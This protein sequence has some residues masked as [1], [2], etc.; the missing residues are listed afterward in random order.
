MTKYTLQQFLKDLDEPYAWPGGYPRYFITNDGEAL[1]FVAARENQ[2]LIEQSISE[3][4]N[5]GWQVVACEINWEDSSLT[6]ADTGKPIESAY[7]VTDDDSR[8]YGPQGAHHE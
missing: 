3:G 2:Q 6:C 8:S 4:C 7:D 1:S 5:D